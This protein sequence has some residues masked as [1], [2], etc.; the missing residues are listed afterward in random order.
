MTYNFFHIRL[1]EC[2]QVF[3]FC[4]GK[5]I[6]SWFVLFLGIYIYT[7]H[8]DLWDMHK[9]IT[10]T[11]SSGMFNTKRFSSRISLMLNHFIPKYSLTLNK[12][13]EISFNIKLSI[14]MGHGPPPGIPY[15]YMPIDREGYFWAVN[16]FVILVVNTWTINRQWYN[17]SIMKIYKK[18]GKYYLYNQ[19]GV[20]LL[21]STSLRICEFYKKKGKLTV[22][23]MSKT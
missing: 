23:S 13:S 2:I 22:T 19:E 8:T 17:Y 21:V 14:P 9:L 18:N 16:H 20:L 6:R 10:F 1:I 15:V 12:L 11:Y 5:V 4:S 3:C 7:V